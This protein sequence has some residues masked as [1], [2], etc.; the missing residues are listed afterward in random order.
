[1]IVASKNPSNSQKAVRILIVD[2][3]KLNRDVISR[4]LS[5]KNFEV[6]TASNGQEAVETFEK[7]EPQVILMD[8]RMP[9]MDGLEAVKRIRAMPRGKDPKVMA[10][11]ANVFEDEKQELLQKGFDDLIQKPFNSSVF[12]ERLEKLIK[13]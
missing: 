6:R 5:E 1:V 9:V 3:E 7:W 13:A 2:D 11:S 4:A 10:V 12:F 8:I